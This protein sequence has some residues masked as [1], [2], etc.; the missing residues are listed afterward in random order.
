M[1]PNTIYEVDQGN[2]I[3]VL[4]PPTGA[5][6]TYLSAT[7]SNAFFLY[8]VN[9]D[10]DSIGEIYS[11]GDYGGEYGNVALIACVNGGWAINYIYT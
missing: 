2:Y 10:G 4:C 3:Q 9:P 1:E 11:Y 8:V 5:F 7:T 6:V